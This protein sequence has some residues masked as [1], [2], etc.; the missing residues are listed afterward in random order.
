MGLGGE[1]RLWQGQMGAL[2]PP[3]HWNDPDMFEIGANGGG[4]PKK[5]TPDEQYSHVSLWCLLS[6][7]LLLGCDLEHLNDFTIGLLSNDEV[8]DVD[9]DALGKQAT[10]VSGEGYDLEVYAKPLEDGSLGCRP[11]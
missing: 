9:Q 7:P 5:L 2:R 6:A 4:S 10:R 8:L 11:V 1:H 3:G